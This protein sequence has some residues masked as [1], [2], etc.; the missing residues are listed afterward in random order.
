VLGEKKVIN[1]AE[2]KQRQGRDRTEKTDISQRY[3]RK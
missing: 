1:K 2:R 3:G